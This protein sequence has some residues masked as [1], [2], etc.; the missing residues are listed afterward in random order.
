MLK[1]YIINN[2]HNIESLPSYVILFHNVCLMVKAQQQGTFP[3]YLG[4][5]P[6][7]GPCPTTSIN[8]IWN[9]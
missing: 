7:M 5:T 9:P 1:T 6:T 4:N 8:N 2:V 3:N